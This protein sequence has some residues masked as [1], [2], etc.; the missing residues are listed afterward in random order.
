MENKWIELGNNEIIA[1]GIF[2]NS[3]GTYIAITYTK[4]KTFKTLAG[5]QKW[6]A[7]H[8]AR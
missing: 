7:K 3:D 1:R 6:F 8:T 2:R 5:A 4:S